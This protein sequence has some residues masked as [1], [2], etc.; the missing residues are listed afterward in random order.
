MAGKTSVFV[1][2]S[3]PS[4]DDNW[5]NMASREIQNAATNTGQA[6]SDADLEQLS[7]GMSNAAST[8][9]FFT[10]S[11]AADAYILTS[12]SPFKAPTDF[13]DGML[14][15]FRAGNVNAGASTIVVGA[16]LSRPITLP[17]GTTAL[18]GNEISTTE[19]TTLR[20]DL[21]NTAWV[22]VT[23]VEIATQT[24]AN[25]AT[26]D[27]KALSPLKAGLLFKPIFRAYLSSNQA[28]GA[29]IETLVQ[30]DTEDFDP[31]NEYDNVTN[32]RYNPQ[33]EG[34]YLIVAQIGYTGVS[35]V[36]K[37][38]TRIRKNGSQIRNRNSDA[39]RSG[40]TQALFSNA[41]SIVTLN[42]STDY[43]DIAGDSS[44][45]GNM[46]GSAGDTNFAAFYIG[47]LNV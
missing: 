25:T 27:T 8:S 3:A 9:T 2:N 11:G 24:E 23:N 10:D 30:F 34:Y 39:G 29:S 46:I 4:A 13:F 37:V 36:A 33:R 22:L 19:D 32:F 18:S 12:I 40:V 17:D 41:S 14:V 38:E 28:I 35:D 7:K 45:A 16:L 43:I 44:N 21:A 20:Y 47:G 1:N 15:R 26:N 31:L 6:P 5:L 42:G